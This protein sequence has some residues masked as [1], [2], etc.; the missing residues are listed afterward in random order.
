MFYVRIIVPVWRGHG[1]GGRY[2]GPSL[3]PDTEQLCLILTFVK[4]HGVMLGS[5][6]WL[7]NNEQRDRAAYT[8]KDH[9]VKTSQ[10][11]V[12]VSLLF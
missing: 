12:N 10:G 11:A 3:T 1:D 8:G 4:R 7:T 2:A 5:A 6:I 9:T